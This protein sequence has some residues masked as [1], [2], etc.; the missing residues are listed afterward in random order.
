MQQ[1]FD[2]EAK[3]VL[4]EVSKALNAKVDGKKLSD[5]IA[6]DMNRSLVLIHQYPNIKAHTGSA[7]TVPFKFFDI[8]DNL[9]NAKELIKEDKVQR[10]EFPQAGKIERERF[11]QYMD[12]FIAKLGNK[13]SNIVEKL[14]PEVAERFSVVAKLNWTENFD[15]I[16]KAIPAFKK[17]QEWRARQ[18]YKNSEPF[19]DLAEETELL[20]SVANINLGTSSASEA[21]ISS[22]GNTI[23]RHLTIQDQERLSS[24]IEY[25][26]KLI[27]GQILPELHNGDANSLVA[28]KK[29]LSKASALVE[30][31][32]TDELRPSLNSISPKEDENKVVNNLLSALN[33]VIQIEEKYTQASKEIPLAKSQQTQAK[34]AINSQLSAINKLKLSIAKLIAPIY[35]RANATTKHYLETGIKNRYKENSKQIFD[36]LKEAKKDIPLEIIRERKAAIQ[37]DRKQ[38]EAENIA[39]AK[40]AEAQRNAEI[41][42]AAAKLRDIDYQGEKADQLNQ[43]IFLGSDILDQAPRKNTNGQ[44][45]ELSLKTQD[46]IDK[47]LS[48]AQD[49]FPNLRN[50][51]L[52][53][54]MGYPSLTGAGSTAKALAQ[55]VNED[56]ADLSQASL[57]RSD[58]KGSDAETLL[59]SLT[60]SLAETIAI[61]A[62]SKKQ[63]ELRDEDFTR[64]QE[65]QKELADKKAQFKKDFG[66][67]Y[68]KEQTHMDIS[69]AL[70]EDI[71]TDKDGEMSPTV[72]LKEHLARMKD[73]SES[74]KLT[75]GDLYN[76]QRDLDAERRGRIESAQKLKAGMAKILATTYKDFNQT[77][78]KV[79]LKDIK[80]LYGRQT[81]KAIV[82]E[83][84]KAHKAMQPRKRNF[85]QVLLR[86]PMP[87]MEEQKKTSP[88][89]MTS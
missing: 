4:K 82:Q 57:V 29:G 59:R 18:D 19:T 28:M 15:D 70:G 17:H 9:I 36:L 44:T 58:S 51:L 6:E 86:R 8:L 56:G 3:P 32:N 25:A 77:S 64:M 38:R 50:N 37:E 88:Y 1:S 75:Q 52:E 26:L 60:S 20:S 80:A 89:G 84:E 41:Q 24:G 83:L 72:S 85:A 81:A 87:S 67:K 5:Q 73:A 61:E 65:L 22:D 68:G 2:R 78:R 62:A 23:S 35:F 14:D 66:V 53:D 33:T 55:I 79:Y 63:A 39:E 40:T 30:A 16:E 13:A 12:K 76:L 46:D 21:G 27:Q 54:T 43:A 47:A 69:K 42:A 49:A 11:L 45:Y 34:E 7:V 31:F 48:N 74:I 10:V 71:E